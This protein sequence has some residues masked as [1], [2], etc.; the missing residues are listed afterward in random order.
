MVLVTSHSIT[1]ELQ[2]DID[3]LDRSNFAHGGKVFR[4]VWHLAVA[5]KPG[6]CVSGAICLELGVRAS[7]VY[8]P[9]LY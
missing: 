2:P 9:A 4:I 6:E 7:V 5:P 3:R 8:G 1:T